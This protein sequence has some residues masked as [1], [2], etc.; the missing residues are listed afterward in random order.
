MTDYQIKTPI[1]ATGMGY[2]YGPTSGGS[3][4][5]DDIDTEILRNRLAIWNTKRGPRVG[6]IVI[7]PNGK[8]MRCAYDWGDTIQISNGG[9]YYLDRGHVSMSGPLDPAVPKDRMLYLS[10]ADGQFWFFHHDEARAHN[11][12]S[13]KA[14]C[15]VYKLADD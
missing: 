12:V 6:D 4:H 9:S 5:L 8:W 15:R 13:F 3:D 7:T 10:K 2:S 1:S 14:P 11:G